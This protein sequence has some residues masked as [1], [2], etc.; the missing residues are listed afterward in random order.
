MEQTATDVDARLA[1]RLRALRGERRLTLEALAEASGVSRSMISLIERGG[2]SPTAGVLDRLAAAL[3]LPLAALFAEPPR[4]DASPLARRADQPLWRD[5]ATGYLRRALSP[6]GHPSAFDLVEVVLPPGARV[7]YDPP[8][9]SP[10]LDQQ[11]WVLAGRLRHSL[12]EETVELAEGDCLAMRVDRPNAF[13]NP[14]AEPTRYLV[15]VHARPPGS[16]P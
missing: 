5:P 16:R 6:P 3:G 15:A 13:E 1:A 10:V 8:Q 11:V 14:G 2:A 4:A 12:G 7:A 9:R